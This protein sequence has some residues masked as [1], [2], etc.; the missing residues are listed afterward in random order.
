MIALEPRPAVGLIY[1][2]I[3]PSHTFPSPLSMTNRVVVGVFK[4]KEVSPS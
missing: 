4:E 1:H 2:V 3:R